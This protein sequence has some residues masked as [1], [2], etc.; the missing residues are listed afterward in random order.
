MPPKA[1]LSRV[2][3]LLSRVRRR[4]SS[5]T[6]DDKSLLRALIQQAVDITSGLLDM[7]QKRCLP[8]LKNGGITFL[9]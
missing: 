5:A 7:V 6:Q 3:T 9:N 8:Y 4:K 1:E 2:M